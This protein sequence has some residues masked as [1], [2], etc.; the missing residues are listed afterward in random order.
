MDEEPVIKNGVIGHDSEISD[1]VLSA[2]C[3]QSLE[4]CRFDYG[5]GRMYEGYAKVDGSLI[6]AGGQL[7]RFVCRSL[8]D[9]V[10]HFELT[11]VE[12]EQE[13]AAR[14]RRQKP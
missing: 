14:A 5:R 3:S 2:Y 6:L 10:P 12:R 7:W 4:K 9:W 8:R 1:K 11:T 13:R